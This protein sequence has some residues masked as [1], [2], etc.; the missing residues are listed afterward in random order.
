[1]HAIPGLGRRALELHAGRR[2]PDVHL[3]PV[4]PAER[5]SGRVDR[6]DRR[7]LGD[8][9]DERVPT[10]SSVTRFEPSR[11]QQ[12]GTRRSPPPPPAR[13]APRSPGRFR[14]ARRDLRRLGC[15]HRPPISAGPHCMERRLPR[16]QR[17]DRAARLGVTQLDGGAS[18]ARAARSE[19]FDGDRVGAADRRELE[20]IGSGRL[21]RRRVALGDDH[22]V[23]ADPAGRRPVKR[24][25]D[26]ED[27]RALWP[28]DGRRLG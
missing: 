2:C 11:P 24:A 21:G 17:R 22:D 19:G 9:G 6:A 18:T 27:S 16:A 12:A 4:E 25:L 28:R 8:V 10:L 7:P 5:R 23:G 26:R 1:M 15:R 14:A 3:D 13:R 20:A